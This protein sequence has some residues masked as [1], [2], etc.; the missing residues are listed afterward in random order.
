MSTPRMLTIARYAFGLWILVEALSWAKVL[1][2]TL[3]FTWFGLIITAVGAWAALEIISWRLRAHGADL[4][5]GWTY[6]AALISQCADA[7]GDI[8]RLYGRFGWYDQVA[9]IIGGAVVALIFFN[10]LTSLNNKKVQQVG[11]KFR[12][13]ISVL[14]SMAI[15]SLYEIEEY[16]EDIIRHAH[17]LGDAFDTA[18]DMLCNAIGAIILIIVIVTI[19]HRRKLS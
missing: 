16:S 15:G 3:E 13:F 9:H 1:P 14:G 10:L 12:G 2:L 7:C 5:W 4:L 11:L 17:R 6:L 8:F 19:R 18:N